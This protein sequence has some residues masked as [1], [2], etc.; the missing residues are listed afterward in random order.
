[1]KKKTR[2]RILWVVIIGSILYGFKC[3]VEYMEKRE[4]EKADQARMDKMFNIA[5]LST[6][7]SIVKSNNQSA[8][9]A[10][11]YDSLTD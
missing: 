6:I 5:L 7:S 9:F 8:D 1:M 4:R 2:E 3:F 11:L 10:K